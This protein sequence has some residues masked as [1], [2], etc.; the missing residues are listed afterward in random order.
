[1]VLKLVIVFLSISLFY[2]ET[3]NCF[4]GNVSLFY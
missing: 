4:T 3:V 1:M 2:R